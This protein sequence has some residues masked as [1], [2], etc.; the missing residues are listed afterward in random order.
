MLLIRCIDGTTVF[1]IADPGRV[2]VSGDGLKL[3]EANRLST[4]NVDTKMAGDAELAVRIAGKSL[5]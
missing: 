1:T 2:T 3:A 4:F 5:Q